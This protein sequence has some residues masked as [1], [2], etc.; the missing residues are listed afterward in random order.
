MLYFVHDAQG[1]HLTTAPHPADFAEP[2]VIIRR[3]DRPAIVDHGKAVIALF[4]Q[5][6]KSTAFIPLEDL[7]F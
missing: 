3:G 7:P 1:G 6:P 4:K 2:V 5:H